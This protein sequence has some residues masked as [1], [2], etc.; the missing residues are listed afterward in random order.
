MG[1]MD[2]GMGGMPGMDGGT[3]QK[4]IV[5][6]VGADP[7]GTR[8]SRAHPPPSNWDHGRRGLA[9][10]TQLKAH[11]SPAAPVWVHRRAR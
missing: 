10:G 8:P 9:P 3:G 2:G 1:G 4:G 11:F 5:K 7:R 6:L